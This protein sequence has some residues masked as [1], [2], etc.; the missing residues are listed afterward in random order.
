MNKSDIS[1]SN[2]AK[3]ALPES[4]EKRS[5]HVVASDRLID[6]HVKAAQQE[7]PL[8]LGIVEILTNSHDAYVRNH[9]LNIP[10]SQ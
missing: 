8:I 10:E 5:Y 7:N 4:G 6:R 1:K 3:L 9:N 2:G